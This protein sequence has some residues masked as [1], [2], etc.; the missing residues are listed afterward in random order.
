MTRKLWSAVPAA[1]T[2]VARGDLV[3]LATPV[4]AGDRVVEAVDALGLAWAARRDA[5]AK[6]EHWTHTR[7]FV[8]FS[9][10]FSSRSN[11]RLTAER[12]V[13]EFNPVCATP[14]LENLIGR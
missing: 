7:R 2:I 1:R 8:A 11:L 12:D 4:E 6:G 14:E 9:R 3:T 13:R 5:I 10:W